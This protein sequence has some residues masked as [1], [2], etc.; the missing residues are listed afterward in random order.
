MNIH[1]GY[2]GAMARDPED[3]HRRLLEAGLAEFAEFGIAGA[4]MD[5]LGRRAGC[6]VGLVY[7]Y[8][9]S[10]VGLFEAIL[11]QVVATAVAT[12]PIDVSDLG[13]YAGKLYDSHHKNPDIARVVAWD[14]LEN[15]RT[16]P[17]PA[18]VAATQ[19]K[20]AAI[21]DAQA[22]GL[23]TNRYDAR[24]LL[25]IVQGMALIWGVLPDDVTNQVADPEDHKR[26][27]QTIVDAVRQLVSVE[28]PD[29][30]HRGAKP[31]RRATSR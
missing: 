17:H 18:V 20:I 16:E 12:T 5:R 22:N 28:P 13:E 10:K 1:S 11:D 14:R 7:T 4:R 3:K 30:T 9:G 31:S 27:R 15:T 2:D 6:S 26:R 19:N 29:A 21:A 25:L 23:L 24:Q 8:F